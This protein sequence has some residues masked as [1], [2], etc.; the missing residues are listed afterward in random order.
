MHR[1]LAELVADEERR[2]L[3]LALATDTP[4]EELAARIE[5][6][7]ERAAARGATRLASTWPRTPGG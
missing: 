1:R 3:H 4:D 7:A 5:K 2:A 6:A